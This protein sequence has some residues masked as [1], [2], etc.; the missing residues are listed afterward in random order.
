[1]MMSG[2]GDVAFSVGGDV[3]TPYWAHVTVGADKS[4]MREYFAR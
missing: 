2:T 1:M 4:I 3:I